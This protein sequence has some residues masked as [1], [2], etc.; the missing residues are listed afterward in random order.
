M[1]QAAAQTEVKRL[2]LITYATNRVTIESVLLNPVRERNNERQVADAM[3]ISA[4]TELPRAMYIRN[5][6]RGKTVYFKFKTE[7]RLA[8]MAENPSNDNWSTNALVVNASPPPNAA[9]D[10][11]AMTMISNMLLLNFQT[12]LPYIIL[13]TKS[14]AHVT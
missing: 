9:N 1:K 5:C 2:E 14:L 12:R 11:A 4:T 10:A 6:R 7:I 3:K 13:I 8:E